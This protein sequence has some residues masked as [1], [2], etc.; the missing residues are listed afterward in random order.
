ME[1]FDLVVVG[2][3]V[4]GCAALRACL[5]RNP[6]LSSCLIETEAQVAVH[7]SGRNSG[8]IHGGYNQ[9]PG[10][11]KARFVVEGNRRL[12]EYL[13]ASGVAVV[14]DGLL[15]TARQSAEVDTLKELLDRGNKNGARVRLVDRAEMKELEPHAAGVAGLFAAD[16]ASFDARSYVK[17]LAAE[18]TRL[19]GRF[20]LCEAVLDLKET[21]SGVEVRT[22]K[23]TLK[24]K[25]LL[26]AAGL[27]ADQLAHKLKLGLD[28]SVIPFRGEYHELV[29]ARRDLVRAHIYPAPNLNFPFL[30]VHLSRT[31]DGRVTVGP[32][33]VLALGRECYTA[34]SANAQDLSA[35]L[36]FPGLWKLLTNRD[37]QAMA[38]REWKKSLFS[39]AV[40]AEAQEL[41]PELRH[42]D[43]IA[44]PAGVRAQLVSR[45]G[46]LVDDLIVEETPR[47]VHVLNA[48]SPALTCSLPFAD[49]L[50]ETVAKKLSD[51]TS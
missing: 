5:L 13:K 42:A 51:Q 32:G 38:A 27:R 22:T 20:R 44:A 11:A 35:M 12:R 26:C 3:G 48:V 37:F 43:L 2:G 7:Q 15:V 33:A 10:T 31:F 40:T 19:G 4:I 46:K 8:V 25:I 30:G 47:T 1:N 21:S 16:V 23:E 9:K 18:A 50:A 29:P 24:T 39:R 45:D 14:E 49:Q 36:A 41:L 28:Y 6:G 34:F 17:A